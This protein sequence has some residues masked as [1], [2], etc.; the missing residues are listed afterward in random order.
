MVVLNKI[1]SDA[2]VGV[3]LRC[4]INDNVLGRRMASA[5]VAAAAVAGRPGKHEEYGNNVSNKSG[6]QDDLYTDF[7]NV[8]KTRYPGVFRT[9][10]DNAKSNQR[11][12]II[13]SYNN[14]NPLMKINVTFN[15]GSES[16]MN[17]DMNFDLVHI[18]KQFNCSIKDPTKCSDFSAGSCDVLVYMDFFQRILGIY[19]TFTKFVASESLQDTKLDISLKDF[20]DKTLKLSCVLTKAQLNSK[21]WEYI[22]T[23]SSDDSCYARIEFVSYYSTLGR[24]NPF[25]VSSSQE[26][27]VECKDGN[28]LMSFIRKKQNISTDGSLKE[29]LLL[30][31]EWMDKVLLTV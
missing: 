23:L 14:S 13:V 29:S 1:F 28:E 22:V 9:N 3:I 15:T 30:I 5:V 8:L 11:K 10:I 7:L 20:S 19:N 4:I 24:L 27:P 6:I 17:I 25:S 31:D 16:T 21:N 12:L 2:F 18:K 26:A